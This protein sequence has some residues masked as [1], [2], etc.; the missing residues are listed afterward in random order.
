MKKPEKKEGP[1]MSY[2]DPA[3]A[4]PKPQ[5]KAKKGKK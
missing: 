3:L 2:Q 4:F 1:K 5:K